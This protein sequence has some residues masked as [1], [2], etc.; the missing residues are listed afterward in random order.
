MAKRKTQDTDDST[1]ENENDNT[2][3]PDEYL[4]F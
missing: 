1:T 4:S 2:T 3:T